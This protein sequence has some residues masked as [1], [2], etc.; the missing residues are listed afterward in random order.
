MPSTEVRCYIGIGS[1]LGE[2][3]HHVREA[4]KAL[5]N[6]A[7]IQDVECSQWYRSKAVGPGDQPDY[8]NGVAALITT[9]SAERLLDRLQQ[10]EKKQGRKRL[11][12]WGART[13]DLDLLLYGDHYIETE[14]LTVPHPHMRERNFVIIPLADLAPDL[15]LKDGKSVETLKQNIGSENIWP[16]NL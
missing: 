16:D 14:R 10:I 12:K 1:N 7:E 9:L 6:T 5:C 13:L 3:R 2:S 8:I 11:I 4:I 15:I